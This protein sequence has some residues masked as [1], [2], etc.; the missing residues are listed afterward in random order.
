M[1][2][3]QKFLCMGLVLLLIVLLSFIIFIPFNSVVCIDTV[4]GNGQKIAEDICKKLNG[5]L[6]GGEREDLTVDRYVIHTNASLFNMYSA[7]HIYGKDKNIVLWLFDWDLKKQ[8]LGNSD[9]IEYMGETEY[10]VVNGVE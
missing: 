9:P 6:N 2:K 8:S 4:K 3:K 10:E 5:T 7:K 1:T